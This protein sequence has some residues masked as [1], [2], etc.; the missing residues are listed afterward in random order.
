MSATEK[1]AISTPKAPT[2]LGPYNQA[3]RVGSTVFLSGQIGF[4]PAAGALVTGGVAAE[5][6][7]TFENI[8][9]VLE[10][11][12]LSLAHVVKTTVFL[13]DMA[14]FATMN[15]IYARYLMVEG[16]VAPARST[17]QAGRLPKDVAVEIECI[18]VGPTP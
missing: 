4:D 3:V 8:K 18:A 13:R 2:A 9:A 11:A 17:I 1:I 6:V 15:E 12:G 7:Q 10:A 5:T 16:T 14:D